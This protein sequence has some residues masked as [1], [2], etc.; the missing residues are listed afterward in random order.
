MDPMV[1]LLIFAFFVLIIGAS[2][3]IANRVLALRRP[4]PEKLIAYECGVDP[5][6][7][8]RIPF[9]VKFYLI[10]LIFLIFDV[11]IVF[12]YPWAVVFEELGWFGFVEIFIFVLML[13]GAY[14]YALSE[15]GLKWE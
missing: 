11:E 2:M 3:L 10:A 1:S 9:H 7:D 4:K 13:F 14:L 6:G 12:L 15:G 8:A 5:S